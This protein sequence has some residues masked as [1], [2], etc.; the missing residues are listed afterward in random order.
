MKESKIRKIFNKRKKNRL[1][2]NS[3][4][5]GNYTVECIYHDDFIR[6]HNSVISLFREPN[7]ITIP[8]VYSK[9]EKVKTYTKKETINLNRT[10]NLFKSSVLS[11]LS[12]IEMKD[13]DIINFGNIIIKITVEEVREDAMWDLLSI[14]SIVESMNNKETDCIITSTSTKE[15]PYI[16]ERK[17]VVL[18]QSNVYGFE[19]LKD[20]VLE[21]NSYINNKICDS[22]VNVIDSII[23]LYGVN[24]RGQDYFKGLS[25]KVPIKVERYKKE[26]KRIQ[27]LSF[28]DFDSNIDIEVL[29]YDIKLKRYVYILLD[30]YDGHKEDIYNNSDATISEISD[31]V[32]RMVIKVESSKINKIYDILIDTMKEG[33]NEVMMMERY[34]NLFKDTE[35]EE[36]FVER[37]NDSYYTNIDE[38]IN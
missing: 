9:E 31:D 10:N 27:I 3:N 24:N 6:L 4:K 25:N 28:D 38:I 32:D 2:K 14:F 35:D 12:Y 7:I 11:D 23:P 18:L 13:K 36:E 37:S 5:Y 1:Y 17:L 20:R 8:E 26:E 19:K 30:N 16:G 22:V 33:L 34:F 29:K 21:Y 15:D